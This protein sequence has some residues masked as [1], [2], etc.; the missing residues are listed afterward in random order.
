[1]NKFH[2]HYGIDSVTYGG[3]NSKHVAVIGK[4][5]GDT[6]TA[7]GR[8]MELKRGG[9]EIMLPLPH[10]H[11][12]SSA[13]TMLEL[14]AVVQT[15]AEAS[16]KDRSFAVRMDNLEN[17]YHQWSMLATR[18]TG[19]RYDSNWFWDLA[20]RGEGLIL[21]MKAR[22]NRPRPYQL[23]PM[24]DKRI[25]MLVTDPETPSYPSG[26]AYDAG[27]FME[28]LASQHPEFRSEFERFAK[29]VAQSRIIAGV[30]FP[31]D[32]EVGIMLGQCV[33]RQGFVDVQV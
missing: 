1:M 3:L 23:G 16:Q 5:L 2:E 27:L 10:P 30:H 20:T 4:Q 29:A 6:S 28:A 7:L 33:V 18:L 26:H 15:M 9:Y 11:K 24:L 19:K 8:F 22:F 25:E 12:N 31:S 14:N 13:E 21:Y 17:H 32:C